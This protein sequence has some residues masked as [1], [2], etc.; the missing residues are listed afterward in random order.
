MMPYDSYRLYQ[1]ERAKSPA[2]IRHA[3]E[4][5][6]AYSLAHHKHRH[7]QGLGAQGDSNSNFVRTTG[8]A[9]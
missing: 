7:L 2:E 4:Q 3:D 6:N 8:N 9:V 1:V 5:A